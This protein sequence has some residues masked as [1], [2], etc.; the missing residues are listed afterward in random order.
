MLLYLAF[1]PETLKC[2]SYDSTSFTIHFLEKQGRKLGTYITTFVPF[3]VSGPERA[4]L[5]EKWKKRNGKHY[6][7]AVFQKKL[8]EEGELISL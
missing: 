5:S 1:S 8:S 4:G 7:G 3:S 2:T 6:Y